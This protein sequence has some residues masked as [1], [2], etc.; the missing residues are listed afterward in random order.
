MTGRGD[1]REI[2]IK[3]DKIMYFLIDYENV[4]YAGLEGTEFLQKEDTVCIFFSN[5][6]DKIVAY[7]MKDIEMSG[8]NFE[9]CK[10]KNIRKNALD[11]Y[12][13]SKVGEIL[14]TDRNA[15]IA[16]ISADNG[17]ASVLDYWQARLI[18][19]N[20][21]VRSRTIAKAISFICGEDVRKKLVN[22]RL[23][24]LNLQTEFAKYEERNRIVKMLEEM[25][26][27]T[28]YERYIPNIA[29]MLIEKNTPKI[30]YLNSLKS[31]GKKDGTEVYRKIKECVV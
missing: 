13:A 6:S 19:H 9:I 28:E 12:I 11:F 30:L 14:A 3:E 16:I 18:V 25:L 8:C 4:N 21:L 7:R 29:N 2:Q 15:K 31:F 23:S 5:V 27:D 17:F 26:G 20:Q 1:E 22:E 24:V 10:L